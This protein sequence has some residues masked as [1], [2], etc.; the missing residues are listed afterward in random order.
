MWVF[1]LWLC[2]S[3]GVGIIYIFVHLGWFGIGFDVVGFGFLVDLLVCGLVHI[4]PIEFVLRGWFCLVFGWMICCGL[5]RFDL[6]V[7]I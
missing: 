1:E 3:L 2:V 7:V 6:G 5:I 4:F